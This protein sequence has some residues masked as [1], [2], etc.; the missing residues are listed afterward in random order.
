M[1][2]KEFFA[3]LAGT[4]AIGEEEAEPKKTHLAIEIDAKPAKKGIKSKNKGKEI[5]LSE[6]K[7]DKEMD[8]FEGPEGQLVVDVY[9]TPI[10]IIIESHIAGVKADD[11]DISITP[12]SVTIKGIRKKQ[13]KVEREEYLYQEL[14]WGMFSRSI[15]LSQ[16]IDP[17][18]AHAS[19]KSGILKIVL[20]KVN[21]SKTKKLKVKF[22]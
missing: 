15:I 1:D 11:L 10:S 20:P 21:R 17:D 9:Q 16:E 13:E 2:D 5:D 3:K 18:K 4:D 7:E 14:F 22:D 6:K 12:E 8:I 19:F